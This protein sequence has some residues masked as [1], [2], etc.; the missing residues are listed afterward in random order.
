MLRYLQDKGQ[1]F[2]TPKVQPRWWTSS[3]ES[4][5]SSAESSL[6]TLMGPVHNY[7]PYSS[8]PLPPHGLPASYPVNPPMGTL[9][10]GRFQVPTIHNAELSRQSNDCC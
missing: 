10:T 7:L 3:N 2:P 9:N 8:P 5:P 6:S 1:E 4:Y